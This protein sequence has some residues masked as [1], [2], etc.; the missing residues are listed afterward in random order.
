ML[1]A[2]DA[3]RRVVVL[4]DMK[5]LGEYSA[6]RHRALGERLAVIGVDATYWM[7][8]EGP[9]VKG[10]YEG[11]GGTA[12]F[13]KCGSIEELVGEVGKNVRAGDAVLVKASRAVGL[14]RF[15]SG[16]LKLLKA[17]TGD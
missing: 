13:R 7:G 2:L 3:T 9:V 10:G 4:G 1:Q 11:A 14:D 17:K 6:E 12:P 16:L 5:E 15:V 8:D